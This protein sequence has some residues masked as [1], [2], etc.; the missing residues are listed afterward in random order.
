MRGPLE[1]ARGLSVVCKPKE[2]ARADVDVGVGG[3]DDKDEQAAV[4]D[5]LEDGDT[6]SLHGNDK[7]ASSSTR[8]P[9]GAADEVLVRVGHGHAQHQRPGNV[10]EDDAPQCLT[11]SLSD[12]LPGV[13][14]LAKRYTHNLCACKSEAGLHHGCPETQQPAGRAIDEVRGKGAGVAPVR[15]ADALAGWLA[16]HGDDE[17]RE[18]EHGHDEELEARH[19]EL[20]FTKV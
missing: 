8:L 6:G 19:P 4:D 2:C 7:G 3:A 20:G 12:G 9:L 18:D 5:M 1:D 10:E 17:A 11:D 13:R 15:E 14:S 16:A